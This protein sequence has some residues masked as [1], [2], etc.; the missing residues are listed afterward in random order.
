MTSECNGQC[1]FCHR[2]GNNFVNSKIKRMS[3]NMVKNEIIP[4]ILKIGI[5][6]VIFTG[7]EPTMYNDLSTAISMVKKECKDIHVGV[8]TNGYKI[9]SLLEV[10]EFIDKITVSVSSLRKEIFMNYTKINPIH[11]IELLNQ[12]EKGKKAVSIVITEDNVEEIEEMMSLFIKNNFDIKLQFVISE[13]SNNHNWEKKVLLWL[14][15]KYGGFNV[16]LGVTPVLYKITNNNTKIIIKIASLNKWMYDSLFFRNTCMKCAKRDTCVERGCSIRIYPDGKV[17]PCLDHYKCF[18][19]DN[20]QLNL[21][22]A[23]QAL[24]IKM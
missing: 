13:K 22:S 14:I 15:N 5:K 10:Q 19:S 3:L 21:E 12:F 24:D 7:G 16:K 18:M 23:Y 8:T 6:K 11:I 20:V 4:A 1:F 9:E 2:E 17:T